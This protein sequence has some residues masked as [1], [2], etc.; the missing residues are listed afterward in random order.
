MKNYKKGLLAVMVLAAMSS[1][2][3]TSNIIKVTTFDDEN[4]EN[5]NQCSL[6][7]AIET[8]RKNKSFGGCNVGNPNN[9]QT[10]YIQLEAGE[11]LLT[12]GELVPSIRS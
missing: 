8:A 2:A 1:M 6:R 5:L 7:E 3:A 9:G 4:G 12:K 11:Y 10:D